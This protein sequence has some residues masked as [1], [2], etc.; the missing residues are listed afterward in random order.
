MQQGP[1]HLQGTAVEAFI[2]AQ[3]LCACA[4]QVR[5]AGA[6]SSWWYHTATACAYHLANNL[7]IRE[8]ADK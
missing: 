4:Q 8:V 2:L 6:M 1:C 7:V 3:A 5:T